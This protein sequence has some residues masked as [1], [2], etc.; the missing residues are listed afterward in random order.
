MT[1]K[2]PCVKREVLLGGG[3]TCGAYGKFLD[4]LECA[5][6]GASETL[7]QCLS[8]FL[9]VRLSGFTLEHWGYWNWNLQNCEQNNLFH[10][11]S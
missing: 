3:E 9:A 11:I 10:F 6:E 5:L 1:L 7:S 8:Y 2:G 4:H